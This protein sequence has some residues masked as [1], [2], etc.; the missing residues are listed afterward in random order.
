MVHRASGFEVLYRPGAEAT[1]TNAGG[2]VNAPNVAVTVYE[3]TAAKT[4]EVAGGGAVFLH[5]QATGVT[6]VSSPVW[7]S[8]TVCGGVAFGSLV[9]GT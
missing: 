9:S 8:W 4:G 3:P 7:V 1:V 5:V 2:L 6:A